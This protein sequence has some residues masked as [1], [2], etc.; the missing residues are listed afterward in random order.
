M[1]ASAAVSRDAKEKS[2]MK[3]KWIQLAALLVG[4]ASMLQNG[5]VNDFVGGFFNTGWPTD[6]RILNLAIDI[7]NEELFG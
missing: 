6:N 3:R 5:C 2:K 7:L 4:G 1:P